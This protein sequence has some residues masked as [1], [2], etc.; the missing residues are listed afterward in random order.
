MFVLLI[1]GS[2]SSC[3]HLMIPQ[4][5]K[6]VSE[7]KMQVKVIKEQEAD[8]KT[9]V[10]AWTDAGPS[11]RSRRRNWCFPFLL[12]LLSLR[13][14]PRSLMKSRVPS[15][16]VTASTAASNRTWTK[17]ERLHRMFDASG[18]TKKRT[19]REKRSHEIHMQT[20]EV[21]SKTAFDVFHVVCFFCFLVA[22]MAKKM[23]KLEKECHSWKTRFDGCNKSLI[24]MV[25]DVRKLNQAVSE[26]ILGDEGRTSES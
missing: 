17:W 26:G 2:S 8:M 4:M 22:Q 1:P 25:A 6:Q 9:Q 13:C 18:T 16:R 3:K 24:D 12:F 21:Y 15:Q 5:L 19:K 11:L 20:G 7:Y 10:Q 23:K 14:T